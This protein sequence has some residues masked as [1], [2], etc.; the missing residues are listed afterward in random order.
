MFGRL[1]CFYLL[2]HS[3]LNTLGELLQFADRDFYHDWWN[4]ANLA[5]QV[6]VGRSVVGWEESNMAVRFY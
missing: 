2:F 3:L 1:V 6:T 4:A 5:R